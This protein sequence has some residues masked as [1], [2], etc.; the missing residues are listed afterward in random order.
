MS[1]DILCHSG[2]HVVKAIFSFPEYL[3]CK[4]EY[5]QN[6]ILLYLAT[7]NSFYGNEQS[8]ISHHDGSRSRRPSFH[9]SFPCAPLIASLPLNG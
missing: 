2:R 1:V 3:Q 4:H 8:R 6:S 7:L 5:A 9:S